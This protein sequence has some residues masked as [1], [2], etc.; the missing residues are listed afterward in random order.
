[1]MSSDQPLRFNKVWLAIGWLLV[2]LVIYLSLTPQPLQIPGAEGDKVGHWLA[3]ATLMLWFSQIYDM[4]LE[5]LQVACALVALAIGL[6]FAQRYTGYRTFE[7]ADMVAGAAGVCVGWC[8]APPRGPAFL[9][10]F[11][12]HL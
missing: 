2:A 6:E 5:R 4:S 7:I 10:L 3:Y 9:A 8:A 1:M 11:E 12:R